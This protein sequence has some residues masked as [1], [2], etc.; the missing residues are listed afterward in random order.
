MQR[1]VE[2]VKEG[3]S[4]ND[5]DPNTRPPD[6]AP[7]EEAPCPGKETNIHYTVPYYIAV[8]ISNAADCV[9]DHRMNCQA[10][11]ISYGCTY[12]FIQQMCCKTCSAS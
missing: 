9:D 7:C 11:K 10:M 6:S 1:K 12:D 2:C 3:K 5:C 8:C 4:S